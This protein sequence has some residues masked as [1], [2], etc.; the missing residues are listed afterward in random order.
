MDKER[1]KNES[2]E[3][4]NMSRRDKVAHRRKYKLAYDGDRV[5]ME[6][7]LDSAHLCFSYDPSGDGNCHFLVVCE[8]LTSIWLYRSVETLREK[9]VQYLVNHPHKQNFTTVAWPTYVEN[10]ARDGTY[11]DHVTLQASADLFNFQFIV[12]SSLGP[13]A[14]AV[15]S[16]MDSLPLCSFHIDHFAEGDG[17]HYT[18]LQNDPIWQDIYSEETAAESDILPATNNNTAQEPLGSLSETS[19]NNVEAAAEYS[20]A[21]ELISELSVS[22]QD[23]TSQ[24][25]LP[26]PTSDLPL[27]EAPVNNTAALPHH[28]SFLASAD[29]GADILQNIIIQP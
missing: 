26:P 18:G 13:A 6:G 11:G 16:P 14:T 22:D 23:I 2:K 21:Q 8:S 4:G 5:C 20:R 15:I 1:K 19:N 27:S 29:E 7:R 3:D 10:M 25:L 12:I 24:P 9:V 17:E 28:T